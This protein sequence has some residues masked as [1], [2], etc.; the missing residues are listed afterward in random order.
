MSW[1][2]ALKENAR[3][4]LSIERS[5]LEPLVAV[6]GA[7]GVAIVLGLLL[8]LGSPK[9]AVSSAF[10]A[11]AA[12]IATFQRSWR[13]R[14]LIGLSVGAGLGVSTFLGYLAAAHTVGFLALLGVWTLVG[15][16]AW[17]VGPVS[18][19]VATQTVA[20][21][22]ITVTL[23][24]SVPGAAEHAALTAFGGLV[25]AT[26]IVV[27]PIR[28]WGARRDALADAFASEAEY[29]RR[30]CVD[31]VAPFDSEPLMEAR[32]A[33]VMTP[34]QARRRP[35]QLSGY[36]ALAERLRPVLA[37]LADPL[38]GAP[39]EGPERDRAHALLGAAAEVLD[40]V[41]HALR[42]G[43]PVRI[44]AEALDVLEVPESGPILSGPARRSALRL[45]AL[46]ADVVESAEEPVEPAKPARGAERRHL[47]RPSVPKLVPMLLHT[48]RRETRW[49]S[50]IFRHAVRVAVVCCV[51]YLVGRALPLGHGYWAPITSV[52]V[53]RPDFGQTYSRGVGRF[54]G[55]VL[56]VT[57]GGV[58]TALVEPGAY[59]SAG[60]AVLCVTTQY[61]LLRTG[62]IVVSTCV[63]AYVVFLLGIA[64]QGWSQT[65]QDR[66]A[67]T[68]VGG[69]IALV[70]HAL[71][72]AWETPR[73]RDR[74]AEWLEANGRYAAAVFDRYAAPADRR[75]RRVRE[76]LLDARAVRAAWDRGYARA[77]RE[78]VKH[79]GI[80]RRA[81]DEA[82]TA[83]TTMGR[84]VML[85]EAHLPDAGADPSPE[86]AAFSAAVREAVPVAA[87]A[88]RERKPLDWQPVRSALADWQRRRGSD[89]VAV[90]G[91]DLLTDALEDLARA[92][93]RRRSRQ[94]VERRPADARRPPDLV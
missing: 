51:G 54:V 68:L 67:L 28:P 5:R 29:A 46:L 6:R 23:P 48:L 83:L 59:L 64:Q 75:P 36:R 11:F 72:P 63:G 31:P 88:L 61:L 4:G 45:M 85:L 62:Y 24:T 89:G 13:P 47:L 19:L 50:P 70:A 1:S 14:P 2:N 87:Q 53:M 49:S 55:T 58:V 78:P 82:Q 69:V 32:L 20:G 43:R 12:G 66:L 84:A 57:L 79:P 73:L 15:G 7:C 27:F 81:A 80:S 37:S 65:V 33:A 76:A 17:A 90:R 40:A 94:G 16:M 22:L 10:G 18:G 56:G 60:L 34:R 86:A 93:P 71:F 41:A 21:M 39:T 52:M 9:L 42:W 44:P 77:L 92:L 35:R 3:S 25:Q 74:L 8:W 91:A 30:L 26:L 38:V